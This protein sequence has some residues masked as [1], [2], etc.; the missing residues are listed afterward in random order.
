MIIDWK[1]IA[2]NIYNDIK[3]EIKQKKI[4]PKLWAILVWNNPSSLR[5]IKQKQKWAEYCGID[6]ELI[7]L[8][9]EIK[10]SDILKEIN[11]LNL[12]KDISWYIVQL[13]LPEHINEKNIINKIDPEKDI[14]WFHPINVWKVLIWDETWL[15]SCTPKWVMSI[16]DHLKIDLVWKII[17]I[18]WRSNIVWKPMI[19]MLINAWA[20]VSSCNSKTPDISKFTKNS[21][22]VIMAAWKP[23][24]L[25]H[26]MIKKDCVVI[27]VWFT[28]E[29]G[30]IYWDADTDKIDSMWCKI[31]PVPGWVWALTVAMLMQNVLKSYK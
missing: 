20:T 28:V 11:N 24:L 4:N 9:D 25:K 16:F 10:E 13:P 12:R 26:D 23:W 22:I 3:S 15:A 2:L 27:D 1:E 21:D 29:N 18:V 6:F 7:S 19:A 8:I 5:Y 30:K 17:T 14:D 31:T